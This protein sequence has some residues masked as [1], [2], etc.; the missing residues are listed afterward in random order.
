MCRPRDLTPVDKTSSLTIGFRAERRGLTEFN[1]QRGRNTGVTGELL[2]RRN[3]SHSD[4]LLK[5]HIEE[6]SAIG[7]G[8]HFRVGSGSSSSHVSWWLESSHHSSVLPSPPVETG[9]MRV[10][11]PALYCKKTKV[12]V[13]TAR[14]LR[15]RMSWQHIRQL[16]YYVREHHPNSVQ[17]TT[18]LPSFFRACISMA[19]RCDLHHGKRSLQYSSSSALAP[20]VLR[21]SYHRRTP[22]TRQIR[23]APPNPLVSSSTFQP[24]CKHQLVP[25]LDERVV[26][27]CSRPSVGRAADL[28]GRAALLAFIAPKLFDLIVEVDNQVPR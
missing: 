26:P 17:S 25:E 19:A 20:A 27:T 1:R 10:L 7:P 23:Y 13:H 18:P 4:A 6:F 9:L 8:S 16:I 12:R 24:R 15:L 11:L 22:W 28:R 21:P 3:G 14:R 5:C 2:G